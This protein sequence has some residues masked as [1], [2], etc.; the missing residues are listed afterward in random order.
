M[1]DAEGVSR[2][3]GFKTPHLGITLRKAEP[4]DASRLAELSETL[5]Y[6]VEPHVMRD[7]LKKIISKPD[8]AVFVAEM[9]PSLVAGWIH[10]AEQDILE[11]GLSCEIL[12]LVVG[13]DQRGRG[14]GRRLIER[15]EQW[16]L[17]RGLNQLSV[18]SNVNRTESHPF[19]ERLGYTR[20]KTQHAY[21]KRIDH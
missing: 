3:G 7:R 17:E 14:I 1:N 11:A 5:G 4:G 2:R 15:I 6:P 13:A 19:Y 20:V 10:A 18:R 12:G 16:A 9:S 21:Q 8:H